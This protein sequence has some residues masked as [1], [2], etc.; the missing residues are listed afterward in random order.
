MVRQTFARFFLYLNADC[1]FSYGDQ[2][3]I[4]RFR[5]SGNLTVRSFTR[6]YLKLADELI[7]IYSIEFFGK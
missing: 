2:G 1:Y 5:P 7:S 3:L 4:M 6:V